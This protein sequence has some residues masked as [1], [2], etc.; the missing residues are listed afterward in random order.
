LLRYLL[1]GDTCF[2]RPKKIPL[3]P[4]I[5]ASKSREGGIIFYYFLLLQ[6]PFNCC[7]PV[8]ESIDN[9]CRKCYQ[10]LQHSTYTR[11]NLASEIHFF[12]NSIQILGMEAYIRGGGNSKQIFYSVQINK[13]YSLI[14]RNAGVSFIFII[15]LLIIFIVHLLL[16]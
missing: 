16:N 3:L 12:Y 7:F 15:S 8:N 9:N 5:V 2:L 14:E 13:I 10:E 11:K 6:S 1:K 4:V